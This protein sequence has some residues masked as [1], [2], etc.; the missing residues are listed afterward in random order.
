MS[1]PVGF[2]TV[3][4]G[5]DTDGDPHIRMPDGSQDTFFTKDLRGMTEV[6]GQEAMSETP[7]LRDQFAMAA[8]SAIIAV[9][10]NASISDDAVTAYKYADAM[11]IERERA[12]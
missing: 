12:K 11:M 2:E 6:I 3:V 1:Y 9:R 4:T 7:T 5:F 8:L 10:A